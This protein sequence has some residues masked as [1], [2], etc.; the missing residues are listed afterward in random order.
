MM[1]T[2]FRNGEDMKKRSIKRILSGVLV[3]CVG[4]FSITRAVTVTNPFLWG[5]F[6]DPSVVRVEDK[7][8]MSTTTMHMVP[9]VPIL[10][11][12]DMVYWRIIGYAYKSLA[13]SDACNL[14]NGK[15]MY[16]KGSWASSIRYKDGT[17]YVL[18]SSS[19]TDRSHLFS[20]KDP[21]N[22][23]WKEVQLPM[24]H[25]PA[26][27]LDDDGRN[28]I[29]YAGGDIKIV[30]LNADLS[31]VKS[32]GLNK[33]II[34]SA[35]SVAGS[36]M[37]LQAEGSHIQKRNGY[38]YVLNICWPNGGGRTQICHRS[39]SIGGPYEG[40]VVLN[41]KGVAQGSFVQMSDSSWMG[42]LFQD[43]GSVGRSPWL[44]P[45]TWQ[46]DWP[47]YNNNNAPASFDMPNVPASNA[48]GTGF[49]TS[50]NFSDTRMKVEWQW[51]HNPDTANWSLSARPGVY[52]I[53]TSRV[54]NS[55]KNARNTLTQMGFGPKCSGRIALDASGM[56]DGDIAGLAAFQ[57]NTGF[58]AVQKNGASLSIVKYKGTTPTQE[59]SVNINQT[60]V[61]LRIDMDFT[62]KTDKATF[63]YSLDSTSWVSIGSTLQMSYD[64]AVFVGYRF[65]LF[66]YAT[67][68]AGGYADF[69]WF[70]TGSSY[71][72]KIDL[73]PI[74]AAKELP[75]PVKPTSG[76]ST[77]MQSGTSTL[78]VSYQLQKAGHTS[79]L[80]Y[81]TRGGF[82]KRLYNRFDH[83]GSHTFNCQ[84]SG[85]ANGRYMLSATCDGKVFSTQPVL[86]VK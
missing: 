21:E 18:F 4:F 72:Q 63:F 11:S 55:I 51:N 58:V 57:N 46:N 36:S 14:V 65:A 38:Y 20:T 64:L 7:Y 37:M 82:V 41:S 74:T 70:Q 61:Y 56:K 83:A 31:G 78:K 68:T 5:D 75:K 86:L 66:N 16:A 53:T 40:K 79:L 25:D 81:D 2:F 85:F 26:L 76:L 22:G 28:Y 71:S 49:V 33:T 3:C 1:I 39:K 27:F 9:G 60:R 24:Y 80:L 52:R 77:I 62:N 34:P 10:E 8:Y 45:V 17:F 23:P 6:P 67:K 43:N 30:E 54:D 12:K 29:V 44:V 32:G 59:A 15:N 84:I 19:T 48:N 73:Y 35:A 42:V 47:V 50:D 69:D 13:N